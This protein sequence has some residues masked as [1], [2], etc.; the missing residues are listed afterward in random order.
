M[1]LYVLS[2]NK[3]SKNFFI[4]N[5][6]RP[7]A[8]SSTFYFNKINQIIFS[9]GFKSFFFF[10]S[11]CWACE[12][13]NFSCLITITHSF[14]DSNAPYGLHAWMR[15]SLFF[16]DILRGHG[17]EDGVEAQDSFAIKWFEHHSKNFAVFSILTEIGKNISS[18][19][20]YV[21]EDFHIKIC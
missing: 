18:T 19:W 13:N 11:Q 16:N 10:F 6:F 12:S 5:L 9:F 14:K 7:V 15:W 21:L 2:L 3:G 20:N 4:V 1:V 17:V 8:F